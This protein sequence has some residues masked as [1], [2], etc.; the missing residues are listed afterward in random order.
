[1][2]ATLSNN[3]SWILFGF[4]IAGLLVGILST[5]F[6]LRFRKLKKIQKESFDLT[7]GKYKIFRFWQYYGIIILALTGYIMFVIFIPISVEQLLK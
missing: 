1:M 4:G 6:F 5:V 3:T 2:L 7:P